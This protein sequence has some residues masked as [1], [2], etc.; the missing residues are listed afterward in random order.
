MF[1]ISRKAAQKFSLM[2]MLAATF[3]PK[4]TKDGA[5]SFPFGSYRR[6]HS[7]ADGQFCNNEAI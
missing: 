7:S 6:M 4:I 5:L 2:E 1:L 3:A